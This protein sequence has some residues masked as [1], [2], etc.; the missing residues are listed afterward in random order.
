MLYESD[1]GILQ[2]HRFKCSSV[3]HS[4][5]TTCVTPFVS[6]PSLYTACSQECVSLGVCAWV[7]KRVGGNLLL[8]WP[9]TLEMGQKC[10]WGKHVSLRAAKAC[11]GPNVKFQ[12]QTF[13]NG[14]GHLHSLTLFNSVV[15]VAAVKCHRSD[16]GA[17]RK[18]AARGCG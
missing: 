10:H 18:A 17:I 8:E 12:N 11:R 4:R 13:Y 6:Y 9:Q 2:T 1:G 3:Q 16:P 5:H 14:E 7:Y 15:A